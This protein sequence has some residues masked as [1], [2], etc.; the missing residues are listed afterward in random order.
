M[1]LHMNALG[2]IILIDPS[3]DR[4]MLAAETGHAAH[5]LYTQLYC[6]GA[7]NRSCI[8]SAPRCDFSL[9]A[10]IGTACVLKQLSALIQ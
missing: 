10:L 6:R 4:K 3:R 9:Q 5:V 8:K 7:Y 2:I 1:L